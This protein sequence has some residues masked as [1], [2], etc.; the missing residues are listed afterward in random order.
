MIP[1]RLVALPPGSAL[2]GCDLVL[3][4][5]APLRI[6]GETAYPLSVASARVRVA[7]FV[8]FLSRYGV[9]LDYR[10]TL[11]D[12]D[13]AVVASRASFVRKGI[14]IAASAARTSRPDPNHDLLLVHR[15]RLLTPVPGLDPPHRLDAYD[16]DDAL[17]LGSA[18]PA[19]HRFRWVKQETRR[20]I[21]YMRRA[22]LVVVGNSFLAER[23]REH[24]RRVEVVPSCV[25]P[26]RQPLHVHGTPH[27]VTVGWIGSRTTSEYLKPLMPVFERLNG[28]RRRVKLVVVGGDLSARATWLEQR[29]WSLTTEAH[30]LADFDIGIMPLPDSEWARGKC[31]YKILQYFSAGVPAVA[32]PVG[33]SSKLV[34]RERGL[35]ATT[36]EEWF[37]A[38]DRLSNNASEREERGTAARAFVERHYS[39]SRWAPELAQMLQ[40]LAG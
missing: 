12:R 36:H 24:A 16:I 31:G 5:K 25:D 29:P 19:N 9:A 3:E 27:V 18:A 10:P 28:M 21:E 38:L 33:V 6:L 17:F 2:V 26:E 39:Y 22:R 35:L 1:G 23:A 4:G 20:C 30:D 40:S 11:T 13:Y 15:L 37:V 14:A 7:N 8:P 32:S 34:G